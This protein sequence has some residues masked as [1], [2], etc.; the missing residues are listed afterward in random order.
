MPKRF[1]PGRNDRPYPG[2]DGATTVNASA[3]SPPK[4][5]GSVRR[6]IRSRN[7]NTDPGQPCISSSG[8]GFGPLPGTCRKCTSMSC[9][10]A[11]NCGNA[12]SRASCARQS[13]AGAPVLDQP[14]QV[15]DV[16]AIGPGLAGRLIG[17]PRARETLAQ[18]G[19]RGIG[20]VQG[21]GFRPRTH[22]AVLHR[23][24]DLMPRAAFWQPARPAHVVAAMSIGRSILMRMF[25]HPRGLWAGWAVSSWHAPI[26][27]M[28]PGLL[29]CWTCAG[30]DRV[31]DVGCG[32]GVAV[33][34]LADRARHVAG[35]DPSE[36]M[37]RQA[38]RPQFSGD[39]R[40]AGSN[41]TRRRPIAC[42]SRPPVS[43]RFWRVNSMQ[44]WPDASAGLR[45]VSRVLRAG[46]QLALAF[47]TYSGQQREGVPE[48]VASAGFSDCRVIETDE[49]FCVLA[50]A[51][52]RTW[53]TRAVRSHQ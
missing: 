7:S 29:T 16:R 5:A 23:R 30:E 6:G 22:P 34:L 19:D 9:S 46:G 25:G 4:L 10:A 21:E 37:L 18:I 31:L 26:G 12:L 44:L 51:S 48:R 8:Q 33:Q 40:G 41:C 17:E 14:A 1:W 11:L 27:V 52:S 24:R 47:T 36:E 53:E 45:E 2:S 49:A 38:T 13:N 50:S 15:V 39:Q 42:H 3:G 28:P 20:D 43:T 35:I 32:P